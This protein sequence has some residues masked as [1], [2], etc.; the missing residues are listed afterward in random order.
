MQVATPL[1]GQPH[2]D[3]EAT[4]PLVD[5]PDGSAPH[6]RFDDLLDIDHVQ[7]VARDGAS[8]DLNGKDRKS[9]HLL[10]L[11]AGGAGNPVQLGG[12]PVR[13]ARHDL[14]F[15]TVHLHGQV[16]PDAGNELVE[17]EFDRLRHLVVLAGQIG[18]RLLDSF[19]QLRLAGR[20]R[21][22]VR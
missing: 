10:D 12:D 14:E 17:A 18:Q 8:I 22:P 3:V 5:L 20:P 21:P 6:R 15:V 1:F 19:R 16:A 7:P 4:I 9:R 13:L 2:H 11:D